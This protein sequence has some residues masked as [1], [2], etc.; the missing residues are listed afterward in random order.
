MAA[1]FAKLELNTDSRVL[2]SL[3]VDDSKPY[4]GSVEPAKEETT[5]MRL[6]RIEENTV[7]RLNDRIMV[8]NLD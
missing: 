2:V 6:G 4:E 5:H 8:G 1:A 3:L 7:T